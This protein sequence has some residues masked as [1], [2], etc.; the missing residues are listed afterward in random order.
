MSLTF[1]VQIGYKLNCG[2]PENCAGRVYQAVQNV[3]TF[4]EN[5]FREEGLLDDDDTVLRMWKI[6]CTIQSWSNAEVAK[7]REEPVT[8]F[9]EPMNLDAA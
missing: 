2:L 1:T 7:Y 4:T 5:Q 6:L 9:P 3:L 8:E